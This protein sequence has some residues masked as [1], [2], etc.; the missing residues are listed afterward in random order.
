M[1]EVAVVSLTTG[2]IGI[3]IPAWLHAGAIGSAVAF[4]LTFA[5]ALGVAFAFAL[6]AFA[7]AIPRSTFALSFRTAT[8]IPVRSRWGNASW[9]RAFFVSSIMS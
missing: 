7:F 5:F 8:A 6:I 4:S 2:A 3:E 1:S 9:L